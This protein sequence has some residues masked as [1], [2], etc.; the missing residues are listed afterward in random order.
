VFRLSDLIENTL[1]LSIEGDN[2]L[3]GQMGHHPPNVYFDTELPGQL[4]AARHPRRGTHT[5]LMC[6]R[7]SVHQVRSC[8][9][10][11]VLT[12]YGSRWLFAQTPMNGKDPSCVTVADRL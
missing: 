12:E 5:F 2:A 7:L 1:P 9:V 4:G 3:S 8:G 6:Y 10:L 11:L